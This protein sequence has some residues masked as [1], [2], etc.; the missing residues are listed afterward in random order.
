V[1]PVVALVG[2]AGARRQVSFRNTWWW[3]SFICRE[4]VVLL[5]G[6]HSLE[7]PDYGHLTCAKPD[8][9]LSVCHI[10]RIKGDVWEL[11]SQIE[12]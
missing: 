8:L 4:N 5:I 7:V 2:Q 10:C 12:N 11:F 1:G 9:T 6:H 3:L